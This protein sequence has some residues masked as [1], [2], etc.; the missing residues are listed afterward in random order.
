MLNTHRE[1]WA[2]FP[3]KEWFLS[4]W[5]ILLYA[6]LKVCLSR[7]L[8]KIRLNLFEA[9]KW[10]NISLGQHAT[11]STNTT[12]KTCLWGC[13]QILKLYSTAG[14]SWILPCAQQ[15]LSYF[16]F[17]LICFSTCSHTRDNLKLLLIIKMLHREVWVWTRWW[18]AFSN[19]LFL[20]PCTT[21]CAII[22]AWVDGPNRP[23]PPREA[24][25]PEQCG[26]R[27]IL[28]TCVHP[29]RHASTPVF[30]TTALHRNRRAWGFIAKE[31]NTVRH[32]MLTLFLSP[33]V[34]TQSVRVQ[35]IIT[36]SHCEDAAISSTTGTPFG[37][38][39]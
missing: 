3:R 36:L 35:N 25:I 6:P 11:K 16:H 30:P 39:H 7:S 13:N 23:I 19:P 26:T 15:N 12:V 1:T 4:A 31:L 32:A 14:S 27:E 38:L 37:S 9:I 20:H 29:S 33:R 21:P 5:I 24:G 22:H 17:C 2:L 8:G 34:I 28:L 10:E 18:K